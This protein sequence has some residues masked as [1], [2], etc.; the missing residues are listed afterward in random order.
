MMAK[1]R[2]TEN[3]VDKHVEKLQFLCPVSG[4]I[5]QLQ[6]LWKIEEFFKNLIKLQDPAIPLQGIYSKELKAG[7]QRDICTPCS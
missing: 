6:P 5:K 3:S 4:N 7:S 2:K 1:I